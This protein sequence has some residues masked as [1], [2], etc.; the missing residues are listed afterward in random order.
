MNTFDVLEIWFYSLKE[1]LSEEKVKS[2]FLRSENDFTSASCCLNLCRGD[3]EVDLVVWES[4]T[5][6]LVYGRP[7]GEIKSVHIENLNDV[8]ELTNVLSIMAK[9][10]THK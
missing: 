1:L 8:Q 7:R 10:L 5:A 3:Y 4:G 2:N 9:C 6:E